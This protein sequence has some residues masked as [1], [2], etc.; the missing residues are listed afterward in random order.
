VPH[1][2]LRFACSNKTLARSPGNS[3]ATSCPPR[4]LVSASSYSS[5]HARSS[6]SGG[7]Q[8]ANVNTLM[9]NYSLKTS[10]GPLTRLPFRSTLTSTRSAILMN[11]IPLFMP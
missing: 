2:V 1:G 6:F 5:H 11:G 9:S 3:R 10:G 8:V 4:S 7:L